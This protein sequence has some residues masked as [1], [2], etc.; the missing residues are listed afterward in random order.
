MISSC[1]DDTLVKVAR[2]YSVQKFADILIL[3]QTS[4]YQKFIQLMRLL[5][6]VLPSLETLSKTM[7]QSR[8]KLVKSLKIPVTFIQSVYG[9]RNWLH[10]IAVCCNDACWNQNPPLP[11]LQPFLLHALS[12]FIPFIL[13]VTILYT[14]TRLHLKQ[15]PLS[16]TGR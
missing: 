15:S 4:M 11:V 7:Y 14:Y 13:I 12:V 16:P 2:Q 3:L 9:N 5:L 1:L 6:F 8:S 10:I